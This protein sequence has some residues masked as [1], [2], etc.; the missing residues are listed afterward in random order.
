MTATDLTAADIT[1]DLETLLP[2]PGD[3]GVDALLDEA[4]AVTARITPFRGRIASCSTDEIVELDRND[5]P[6]FPCKSWPT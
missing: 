6:R 4:D 1:W 2:D 3:K 5:R